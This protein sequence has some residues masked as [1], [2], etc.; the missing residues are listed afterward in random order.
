MGQR[1]LSTAEKR[2]IPWFDIQQE[3]SQLPS[4]F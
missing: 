4:I 2:Q 3:G 1:E